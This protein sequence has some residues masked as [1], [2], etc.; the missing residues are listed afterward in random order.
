VRNLDERLAHG[1]ASRAAAIRRLIEAALRDLDACEQRK[2]HE[3]ERWVRGWREQPE[4]EAEFGWMRSPA[5]MEILN[6]LPWE[7]DASPSGGRT[8]QSPGDA[9]QPS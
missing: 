7:S 3:R 5:A 6:E 9:D 1:D 2:R 4:T 8:S